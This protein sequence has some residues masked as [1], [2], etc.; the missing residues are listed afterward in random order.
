M[1]RDKEKELQQHLRLFE[2]RFE[3]IYEMKYKVQEMMIETNA[4]EKAIDKWTAEIDEK[5]E[6]M[7]Q[8]MADIKEAIKNWESR[9]SIEQK[10]REEQRFGKKN[11]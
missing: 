1:K 4:K 8:P 11:R 2:K 5:L 7:E 9:K 10:N 3:E 6:K